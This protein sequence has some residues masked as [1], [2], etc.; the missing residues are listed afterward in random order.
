MSVGATQKVLVLDN[1]LVSPSTSLFGEC[2]YKFAYAA[3]I[4]SAWLRST[5]TSWLTPRSG[6]VTP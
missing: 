4:S 6:M 3:T 5:L 1:G 2:G